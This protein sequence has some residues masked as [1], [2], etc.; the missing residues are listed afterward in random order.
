MLKFIKKLFKEKKE[1][2]ALNIP[3]SKL[4]DWLEKRKTEANNKLVNEIS[5]MFSKIKEKQAKILEGLGKLRDLH[6]ALEEQVDR[7]LRGEA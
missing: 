5:E 7:I 2:E 1:L 3:Y 6:R 4:G